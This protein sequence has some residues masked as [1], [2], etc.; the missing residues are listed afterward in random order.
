M[1]PILLALLIS[2]S[3]VQA[4]QLDPKFAS[5]M[6]DDRRLMF[7]VGEPDFEQC[8]ADLKDGG[9]YTDVYD[10]YSCIGD[11]DAWPEGSFKPVDPP[12][13]DVYP[14]RTFKLPPAP[15]VRTVKVRLDLDWLTPPSASAPAT[16]GTSRH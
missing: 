4:F 1:K 5:D 16:V 10:G 2:V 13:S 7:P 6:I 9:R 12:P 8:I 11:P 15:P 3:T 14:K